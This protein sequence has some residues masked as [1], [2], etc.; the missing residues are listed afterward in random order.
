[1]DCA[2]FYHRTCTTLKPFLAQ[3]FDLATISDEKLTILI[4]SVKTDIVI[5]QDVCTLLEFYFNKPTINQEQ[6]NEI[7]PN[8]IISEKIRAILNEQKNESEFDAFFNN[9]KKETITAGIALKDFFAYVRLFITGSPKGL[10]IA[11]L[12]K[13]LGFGEIKNRI[14]R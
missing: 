4:Q 12:E 11:E 2:N 3:K 14:C 6:I 5:L 1:M 10:G 8:Q 13:C 7:I 9:A